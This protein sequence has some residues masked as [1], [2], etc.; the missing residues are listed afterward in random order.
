MI[1]IYTLLD[2]EAESRDQ[3]LRLMS[4]V[5]EDSGAVKPGHAQAVT[6]R[7]DTY[8]TGLPTAGIQVAIPHAGAEWTNFSAL[9][10]CRLKTP[11]SF[12]SM[13]DDEENLDVKLVFM[14]ALKKSSEHSDILGRLMEI[15]RQPRLLQTLCSAENTEELQNILA[16]DREKG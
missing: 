15:F 6:T 1:R 8:P 11:V 12:V 2:L 7:E 3:A 10:F 9:L 4:K 13:A 5:L 16:L 14:L